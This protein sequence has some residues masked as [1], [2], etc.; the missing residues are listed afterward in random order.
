MMENELFS[1]SGIHIKLNTGMNRLGIDIDDLSQLLNILLNSQYRF[2]IKS[3]YSHLA[4][5]DDPKEDNYTNEQARIFLSGAKLLEKGLGYST[6][7]H[8]CNTFGILRHPDLHFDMVRLG[9][10]IF[11]GGCFP[12]S[13]NLFPAISLTTT[14][15]QVCRVKSGSTIGYNRRGLVNRDSRIAI[16]RIGY[17]DGLR[18]HMGNG[19]GYVWIR[20]YRVPIVKGSVCMDMTTIDLT[21]LPVEI[22]TDL[23]NNIVEIFG[24]HIDINEVAQWCD[25]I[26]YELITSINQRVKR[27][28][29]GH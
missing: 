19:N 12:S 6:I 13:F 7:K 11:G 5:S 21:D 1:F 20:N 23:E 28:Y 8:L 16:I 14:I 10:G 4:A 17:A 2:N 24:Q 25:T 9:A 29:I 18:R 26:A 3:I 15:A 22:D 27:I